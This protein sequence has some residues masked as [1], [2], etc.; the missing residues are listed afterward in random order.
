MFSNAL[1]NM[2]AFKMSFDP[3]RFYESSASQ[4]AIKKRKVEAATA[5]SK[6]IL[7]LFKNAKHLRCSVCHAS[8]FAFHKA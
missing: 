4:R 1:I 7:P 5:N 6:S 3:K 2:L 8:A